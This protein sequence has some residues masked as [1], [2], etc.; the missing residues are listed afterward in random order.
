MTFLSEDDLP[1]DS[2]VSAERAAT[3]STIVTQNN[4]KQR[5]ALSSGRDAAMS[6]KTAFRQHHVFVDPPI[7]K[8]LLG[9][10]FGFV[11][12]Q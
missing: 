4:L 6:T 9:N 12:K 10:A 5:I 3:T 11:V 1:Q 7:A 2:I 8:T